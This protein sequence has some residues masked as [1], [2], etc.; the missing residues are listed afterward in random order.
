M[1]NGLSLKT[2]RKKQ[3][4]MSHL[5][6]HT[7]QIQAL[8]WIVLRF[9]TFCRD[10][11]IHLLCPELWKKEKHHLFDKQETRNRA[12]PQFWYFATAV[13]LL[14]IHC[15]VNYSLRSDRLYLYYKNLFHRLPRIIAY[16]HFIFIKVMTIDYQR[17]NQV[18]QNLQIPMA[19]AQSVIE[20]VCFASRRFSVRI[21][22]AS[23]WICSPSMIDDVTIK[24]NL[25][26]LW[27]CINIS[28]TFFLETNSSKC[29]QNT[30][31]NCICCNY[32]SICC[33]IHWAMRR[34]TYFFCKDFETLHNQD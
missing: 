6:V 33:T 7:V 24:Q 10:V 21:P 30:E 2:F 20:R 9:V 27:F 16:L 25:T 17:L 3:G 19:V 4:K 22:V 12:P 13:H 8:F 23:E 34:R 26:K 1:F 14:I 31:N 15:S 5:L 11:R 32:Y 28:L 29:L 18:K